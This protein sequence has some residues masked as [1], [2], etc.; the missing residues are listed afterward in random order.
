MDQ[1]SFHANGKLLLSGEYAVLDGALALALPTRLGQRLYVDAA[2]GVRDEVQWESR[3]ANGEVWFSGRFSLPDWRYISGTDS[4]TGLSVERIARAALEQ[5]PDWM[6][7]I[8]QLS[9]RTELEFP[10]NWGLGSSSSL[11]ALVAAWAQADPFVLSDASFGGSGYDIACARADGPVLFQRHGAHAGYVRIPF[12]PPFREQL[13]FVY[14]G[15]KQNSREGIARYRAMQAEKTELV[16]RISALTWDIVLAKHLETFDALMEAHE[17][18]ISE[19]LEL[20]RAGKLHFPDFW[21]SIKS[22]GAW[23]GDFVLASSARPEAETRE[24]F[25]RKGFPDFLPYREMILG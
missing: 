21:G 2:G 15:K 8:R 14:L 19:A 5:R 25:L 1:I 9:V 10:R 3:D 23:G 4:G 6:N 16:H 20:P 11:I 17:A 12:D 13:Y 18:Y 7:G 24:Y 22:L